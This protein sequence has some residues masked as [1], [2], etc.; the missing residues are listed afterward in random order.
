LIHRLVPLGLA[1]LAAA[2]LLP[3]G[4]QAAAPR[5]GPIWVAEVTAAS[6]TLHGEID[7]EGEAT[8]Y[9][10]EYITDAAYLANQQAGHEPFLGAAQFPGSLPAGLVAVAVSQ[11]VSALHIA[12]TY[13][14]RLT[15]SNAAGPT[16]SPPRTFTTQEAGAAFA[17][18]DARGWELVSPPDKNGGA[19]A[20]PGELH[21]GGVLQAAAGGAGEITFSSAASFGAEAQ[22]APQASQ[23]LARRSGAG[24][25]TQN[26][27]APT[28]SGAYGSA[29]DG[30]P[31]QLFSEGL[32]AGLMLN[33]VHC[34]GEGTGC[35]VAGPPLPG[36]GA[37]AGYQNYYLRN[38][39]SGGYQA[40]V[41][42]AD[43]TLGLS[44]S[45]F[46]VALAGASPDLA[47]VLLSSCAALSA[48]ATEVPAAE[49]CDPAAQNLY[50]WSGGGLTL[51]NLLPGEGHGT[52]GARLAAPAGAI[53]L[54]GS[55]VYFT[56]GESIYLRE[57]GATELLPESG[58]GGAKFEVASADG[59]LAYFTKA[60][61]LYRYAAAGG[62]S[63]LL[64]AEVL[65]V[66]GASA[67][68]SVIYYQTD[69]GLFRWAGGTATEIVP[70]AAAAEA[71]DYPA[72]TGTARVSADGSELLFLSQAGL[73]GYDNLD[74]GTGQADSEVFLYSP[75]G[76]LAC[77]SCNP[78]GER[79]AG[80]STIPG[81][82][83]NGTGPGATQAYKPRD[84]S[85]DGRRVFFTSADTLAALDSDH[86]PDA[87]QWEAAGEGSCAKPAGCLS[88]ISSGSGS[89]ASF[90]DAS[91]D[92][93]DAY[94]L[95]T[96]SL[97]PTDPGSADIYDARVGG[98]FPVPTSPIPCEGDA[99]QPLPSAPE[100]PTVASL[101]PAPGNPALH[102]PP[103]KVCPRKKQIGARHGKQSCG[104]RHKK[105]KKHHGKKSKK[106][107]K[108][109]KHGSAN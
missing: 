60:G 44:A 67:D 35:P 78:T 22:G 77:L 21:A 46:D 14:Y 9:S 104:P 66:L 8:D 40:L 18:P 83:A 87:Y 39:E 37:P 84:L 63:T 82:F 75:A 16:T 47:H 58:G 59:S 90:V 33:G 94:F 36:S 29:P 26:I 42:A 62:T 2:C 73:T 69:S 38:D 54:D 81:A 12:T 45:Q 95:T 103:A 56:D 68:G 108:N 76:G 6:A 49:G 65:G 91:A 70:G 13:H 100:D 80:P 74:A 34:R 64:A 52:P 79:P 105:P 3:A 41:T 51:V 88:L 1:V 43:A 7:P 61:E 5:L 17:L 11:H 53:S 24:W 92:G 55:R 31:Y 107:A 32:G 109:G 19:V 57:A 93:S 97:V 4:A 99:C 10:F 101:I 20:G 25:S 98:G 86:A 15:A 72:A 50:E 27:T 71:G 28:L 23:Y 89:G 48:A 85:A 96:T 102:F 30:V 106:Q